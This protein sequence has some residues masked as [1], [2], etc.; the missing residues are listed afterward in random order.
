[1]ARRKGSKRASRVLRAG[2]IPVA[3]LV[4]RLEGFAFGNDGPQYPPIFIGGLPRAGTTLVYQ[5][6]CHCFELAYATELTNMLPVAPALA[7]GLCRCLGRAYVSDFQ[8]RYGKSAGISSPGE[9]IMWNV[10][11][12][13]GRHYASGDL[14]T[15]DVRDV[16]RMVGRIERLVGRPFVNKNLRHNQRL[17][18]LADLFPSAVFLLVLRNP[19][20]VA[21]SLLRGRME[22]YGDPRAWFSIRPR[23]FPAR[24]ELTPE[25]EVVY[26]IQG[27]VTDLQEDI[28][29]IGPERFMVIRYETFCQALSSCMQQ[30]TDFLISHGIPVRQRQEP[31]A[32]F[33]LSH[34]RTNTL[35][36]AQIATLTECLAEV[37]P[38]GK[39]DDFPCL[40][41]PVTSPS[42]QD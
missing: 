36:P 40:S 23:S 39:Y 29:T 7:T 2:L 11:F 32:A 28:R 18:V 1:M 4:S 17:R 37:F 6:L 21:L 20:D 31:P 15:R 12:D 41:I 9:G 13:K 3:R 30:L 26:Q 19:R 16:V 25:T 34:G 27:L 14:P 8:S 5:V 33:P 42:Y 10:W 22:M 38:E 35:S 24:E